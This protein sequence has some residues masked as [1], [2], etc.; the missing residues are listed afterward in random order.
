[1]H[2]L[3]TGSLLLGYTEVSTLLFRDRAGMTSMLSWWYWKG[4]YCL[5]L[6]LGDFLDQQGEGLWEGLWLREQWEHLPGDQ[7]DL[8]VFWVVP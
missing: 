1:M 7:L 4:V 5:L 2:V 6:H 3:S 8:P